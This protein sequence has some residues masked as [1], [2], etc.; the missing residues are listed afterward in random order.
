MQNERHILVIQLPEEW[1]D[2]LFYDGA[3]VRMMTGIP[4]DAQCVGVYA[5]V[6]RRCLCVAFEHPSFL[7]TPIGGEPP[8]RNVSVEFLEHP[9]AET[10]DMI[11]LRVGMGQTEYLDMRRWICERAAE[12]EG[13]EHRP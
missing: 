12:I 1:L 8:R 10:W 9:M 2:T 7:A 13:R 5:D 4:R 3:T 6:A 11:P